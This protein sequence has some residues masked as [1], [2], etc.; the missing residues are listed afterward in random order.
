MKWSDTSCCGPYSFSFR[1][2]HGQSNPVPL[3]VMKIMTLMRTAALAEVKETV[4]QIVA[5]FRIPLEA[6][7]SVTCHPTRRG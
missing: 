3:T 5:H 7:R 2:R 1:P 6:L 4:E